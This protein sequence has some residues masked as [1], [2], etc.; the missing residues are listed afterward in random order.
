MPA[1]K[2]DCGVLKCQKISK[3]T[4]IAHKILHNM[5]KLSIYR[6]RAIITRSWLE[7]AFEY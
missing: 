4:R 2:N 3:D 1:V 7:T 6:M 5:A